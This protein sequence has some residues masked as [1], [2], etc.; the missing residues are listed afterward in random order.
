M[1]LKLL[2]GTQS[3]PFLGL[4]TFWRNCQNERSNAM[5]RSL[6]LLSLAAASATEVYQKQ[7]DDVWAQCDTD[8]DGEVMCDEYV[9]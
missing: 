2:P 8:A 6:F 1:L 9:C 5:L 7:L 3:Q 4:Q